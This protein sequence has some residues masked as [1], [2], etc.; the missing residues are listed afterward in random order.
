MISHNADMI[1]GSTRA[2]ALPS[3]M[4]PYN[5]RQMPLRVP[6]AMPIRP[7]EARV[8]MHV[9]KNCA[10]RQNYRQ[11]LTVSLFGYPQGYAVGLH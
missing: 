4:F 11:N 7:L 6:L 9:L 8:Q 2:M 1:G 5:R 3:R 10:Y